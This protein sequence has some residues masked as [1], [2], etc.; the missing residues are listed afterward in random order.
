MSDQH[1]ITSDLTISEGPAGGGQN[2]QVLCRECLSHGVLKPKNGRTP[3]PKRCPGCQS[4]RIK[5]HP[6]LFS[7]SIAHMDCDAFYAS[8]EKRDNP[9]LADKPVVIGGGQRGVVSTACYIARIRGVRSAM[10]MFQALKLCPDA[11]VIKPRMNVYVD[12]SRQIRAMMDELTPDVEP[13]SLDEAFMDLSGTQRLHGAPPAVMLARLVKRMKD[14]LGVTGSIGL[15]HNKFLAKVASDLDKPRGFSVIG[16]AETSAFLKDKPVRLIWGIG[17]AAQASLEKAGI[18]SFSDLLR[19][20]RNDLNARFGSMGER[21]WHLARG[22]DRRR[23]S[24][25]A[26]IKSISN[27]TT[28][29]EDTASLEVLDGHLWRLAEKVS[30]RAKAR[31]LAGRVVTLKLKRANHSSLTRRQSLRDAT[32]IADMIYRTARALLDQVGDEGPY[33]LLGCGISD[34]VPETQADITGDLLDPQA[35]QRAKAERA[36]DAIR[37]RF[38]KA[39]IQ[40]GRALR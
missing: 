14:E 16:A 5:A 2:L 25:N 3:N 38:G 6:E 40:K 8:V 10:P 4:S 12:V 39:A 28:F 34:L 36:T 20:E 9:D 35:G 1:P 30:D 26:P 17:P 22:Q 32:Q 7:L 27:E 31:Q 37:E 11:V 19:W 29:F 15:S 18:R 23:V 24:S 33:R 21:L 13:L